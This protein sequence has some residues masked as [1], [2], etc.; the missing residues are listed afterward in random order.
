MKKAKNIPDVYSQPKP[1]MEYADSIVI[2]KWITWKHSDNQWTTYLGQ[3]E[4]LIA[5]GL[6]PAQMIKVVSK[7]GSK[8]ASNYL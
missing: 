4:D 7:H 8:R 5:V 3:E 6:V 2:E 1:R